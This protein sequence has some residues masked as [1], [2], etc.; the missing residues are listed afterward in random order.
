[1]S[2]LTLGLPSKGRL[3]AE[4]IDWFARRGGSPPGPRGRVVLFHDTFSTYHHPQVTTLTSA[5]VTGIEKKPDGTFDVH[6]NKKATFVDPDRCTGCSTCEEA[7]TVA[8][9]DQFNFDLIARRAVYIPY[10]QAVPKKAVI[11]R[12]G[13]SPC[14]SA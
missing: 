1:M 4:T 5:E 13:T 6:I 10:S 14:T 11:E 8:I 3:Q 7:C 9:P 12:A 2:T